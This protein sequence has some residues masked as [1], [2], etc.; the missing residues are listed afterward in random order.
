[1][2]PSDA[3]PHSDSEDAQSFSDELS[4][5]DGYFRREVPSNVMVPDPTQSSD[6]KDV[7]DKVLIS[8]PGRPAG[9][10]S[11]SGSAN[12]PTLAQLLLSQNNASTAP[13][14]HVSS[15][16]TPGSP[17]SPPRSRRWDP[18][19]PDDPYNNIMAIAPPPA[20][21][22]SPSLSTS[23]QNLREPQSPVRAQETRDYNTF[24]Q[25]YLEHHLERGLPHREPES[26]GGPNDEINEATPLA[27]G[28]AKKSSRR[29]VVIKKMLF[30]ALMLWIFCAALGMLL[31]LKKLVRPLGLLMLI[32]RFMI[33][34]L[35]SG[36]EDRI[37]RCPDPSLFR[38]ANSLSSILVTDLVDLSKRL[39]SYLPIPAGHIVPLLLIEASRL[40]SKSQLMVTF[41]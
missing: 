32:R 31:R 11:S 33:Q 20:Y 37:D 28:W 13:M 38:E 22:P 3:H 24:R 19:H 40:R 30:A 7:E 2:T 8:K 23:P 26:M 14:A 10:T 18:L 9:S 36:L 34:L 35:S 27:G 39:L 17:S 25:N 21:S 41:Q 12:S 16:P 15:S 4:P 29:R 1:M 5:S 6:N